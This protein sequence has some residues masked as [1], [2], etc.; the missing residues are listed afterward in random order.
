MTSNQ[1]ILA[2]L[3]AEKEARVNEKEQERESRA[4]EREEDMKKLAEM[5]RKEV[6][7]EVRDTI[8]PIEARLET[9]ERASQNLGDQI[10]SLVTEIE[11]LKEEVVIIKDLPKI[12]SNIGEVDSVP[13]DSLH[14]GIGGV[15][16]QVHGSG[17][18]D[19]L[20]AKIMDVC[21]KARRIV[22]FK[23]I[24]HRMLEIQMR[25]YGAKDLEE[26]MLME[27]KSYLKCEMKVKPWQIERL[28][29]VRIFPPNKED[30]NTLYVEFGSEH[31]V[32]MVYKHTWVMVKQDHNVVRWYPKELFERFQ[33]LDSLSYSMR[34]EMKQKG[35]RLRTRITVGRND[36]ELSTK[37]P[38]GRWKYQ[39]L[40]AGLPKIDLECTG[41]PS[42]SSSPPPGRPDRIEE[43]RKRQYSGSEVEE[44]AKKSKTDLEMGA[45]KQGDRMGDKEVDQVNILEGEE[46]DPGCFINQEAYCPKTPAKIKQITDLSIINSPVFHTKARGTT[47]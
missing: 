30:W 29:F 47:A 42:L 45:H 1:D 10:K 5:I 25:S 19:Q 18:A 3:K 39:P 21:S 2:F 4:K 36:L 40:P 38:D 17:E 32:N 24:E 26:A 31:E 16:G 43:D 41:R 22:G 20:N 46:T 28:N 14:G 35:I 37:M 7:D 6:R 23:P 8:K 11:A 13:R 15:T 12:N 33:A 34:E 27:V 9:Q 44:S